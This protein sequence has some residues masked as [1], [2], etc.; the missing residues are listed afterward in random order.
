[1]SYCLIFCIS[2]FF[3][4]FVSLGPI[5]MRTLVQYIGPRSNTLV[6]YFGPIHWTYICNGPPSLTTLVYTS[7]YCVSFMFVRMHSCFNLL[8]IVVSLSSIAD[9]TFFRNTV[10]NKSIFTFAT[11]VFFFEWQLRL[12]LF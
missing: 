7:H 3:C 10:S 8:V 2:C 6:L 5:C 9:L 4:F 12:L 1:M 11:Q